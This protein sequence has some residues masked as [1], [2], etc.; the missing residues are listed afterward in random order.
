LCARSSD[1]FTNSP[2]T[3]PAGAKPGGKRLSV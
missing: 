3:L 1:F 2:G